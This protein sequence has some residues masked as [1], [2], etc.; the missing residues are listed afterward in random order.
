[1][2]SH[3]TILFLFVTIIMKVQSA[4]LGHS[5][6]AEHPFDGIMANVTMAEVVV[7]ATGGDIIEINGK[8]YKSGTTW[9]MFGFNVADIILIPELNVCSKCSPEGPVYCNGDTEH[10]CKPPPKET[11]VFG[12]RALSASHYCFYTEVNK[13]KPGNN[14]TSYF[15]YELATVAVLH[16]GGPDVVEN[17][18]Y[19]NETGW[20]IF[21]VDSI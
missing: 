15:L 13:E 5:T 20:T 14:L 17:E 19:D 21:K 8:N 10:D 6:T 3:F 7:S 11:C 2:T 16:Y 12:Y 9:S 1:M 18:G 4:S